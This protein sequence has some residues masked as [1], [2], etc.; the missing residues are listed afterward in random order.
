MT[1]LTDLASLP[2]PSSYENAYSYGK[3]WSQQRSAAATTT[4]VH[5]LLYCGDRL[6]AC[7]SQ[8]EIC[9]W[10]SCSLEAMAAEPSQRIAVV[11]GPLHTLLLP[12]ASDAILLAAGSGGIYEIT[13]D[14]LLQQY[15]TC[16]YPLPI[17]AGAVVQNACVTSQRV[18]GATND[19]VLLQWDRSTGE[20][21]QTITEEPTRRCQ[22]LYTSQDKAYLGFSDGTVRLWGD[23]KALF[24]LDAALGGTPGYTLANLLVYQCDWWVVAA[25]KGSPKDGS[26]LLTWHRP[27]EALVA[28]VETREQVRSLHMVDTQLA[29][30]GSD[31]RLHYRDPLTLEE[32]GSGVRC[33]TL[34][35]YSVASST[36]GRVA[37]A[38]VGPSISLLE[39]QTL[40]LCTLTV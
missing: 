16:R 36:I 37:V 19:G 22:I 29:T 13:L 2:A 38:G 30:T 26:V 7:T 27:T 15:S 11:Q 33:D 6:L 14:P 3:Q 10:D 9:V 12:A 8:G 39:H 32:T 25:W 20:V 28:K 17:C 35:G 21:V 23:N 4:Q 31:G 1:T 40:K 18:F 5:S 34:S 24:D